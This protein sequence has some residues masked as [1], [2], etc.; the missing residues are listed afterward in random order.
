MGRSKLRKWFS[1]PLPGTGRED[2]KMGNERLEEGRTRPVSQDPVSGQ[3]S[4]LEVRTTCKTVVF[5]LPRA[6]TR[7]CVLP[8]C[9]FE[10]LT[11]KVMIVETGSLEGDWLMK[12]ELW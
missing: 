7:Y 1:D 6:I 5:P 12:G 2:P 8:N 4:C 9:I 3:K 10:P 11:C